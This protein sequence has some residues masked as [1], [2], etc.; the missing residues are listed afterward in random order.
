M[1]I[2]VRIIISNQVT[3]HLEDILWV[4]VRVRHT[5]SKA[6]PKTKTVI[7]ML[8]LFLQVV[9]VHLSSAPTATTTPTSTHAHGSTAPMRT[10]GM[11]THL[12]RLF[13][14]WRRA[15]VSTPSMRTRLWRASLVTR[16]P[17]SFSPHMIK[18]SAA[19]LPWSTMLTVSVW[20]RNAPFF[21]SQQHGDSI[22]CLSGCKITNFPVLGNTQKS[23]SPAATEK[24]TKKRASVCA[25]LPLLW[26][27]WL[28][29]FWCQ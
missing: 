14:A 11:K 28:H 25:S 13:Q 5:R 21:L 23:H 15:S 20:N 19:T 8:L 18:G 7:K 22:F 2:V 3:V 9:G 24:Q 1:L 4:T 29:I 17:L 27:V 26:T 6:G 16:T 12:T 10:L